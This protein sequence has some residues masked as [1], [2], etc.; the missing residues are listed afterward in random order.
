MSA[1]MNKGHA[2][3]A[4]LRPLMQPIL[5]CGFIHDHRVSPKAL[6]L[7]QACFFPAGNRQK[8]NSC[9]AK[10]KNCGISSLNS[11]CSNRFLRKTV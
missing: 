2:A 8:K 11:H 10:Q 9:A 7:T 4:F 5:F 1:D 3:I 6:H